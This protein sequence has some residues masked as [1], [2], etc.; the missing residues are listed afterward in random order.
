M[1]KTFKTLFVTALSGWIVLFAAVVNSQPKHDLSIAIGQSAAIENTNLMIK[2]KAVLEDSRCPVNAFC[3]LPGNGRI[4]LEVIDAH[5][6]PKSVV[7]S[8]TEEPRSKIVMDHQLTLVSLS[9]QRVEGESFSE[10]DYSITLRVEK[11]T[12]K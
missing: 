10:K 5:R 7:L 11:R 6:N 2:F 9:P 1:Q 3:T 12:A 8:T 4:E